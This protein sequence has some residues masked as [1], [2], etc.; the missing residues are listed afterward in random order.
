VIRDLSRRQA[1]Q[2]IL[3]EPPQ[4]VTLGTHTIKDSRTGCE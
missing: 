2:R 1:A 4:F 3:D